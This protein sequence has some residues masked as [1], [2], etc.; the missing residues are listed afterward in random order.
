MEKENTPQIPDLSRLEVVV[1]YKP[2]TQ[3][4]FADY[5]F[6]N[7]SDGAPL[8]TEFVRALLKSLYFYLSEAK[9]KM[10]KDDIVIEFVNCV[11]NQT[12]EFQNFH[13]QLFNL[14]HENPWS[15]AHYLMRIAYVTTRIALNS[16]EFAQF[17]HTKEQ[18]LSTENRAAVIQQAL[19]DAIGI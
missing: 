10:S 4:H 5:E 13:R 17:N 19:K 9:L 1:L 6:E 8:F 18:I 12:E 15:F 2:E 11:Y 7:A 16:P 3:K 14:G